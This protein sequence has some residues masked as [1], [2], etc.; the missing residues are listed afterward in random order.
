MIR[1]T[2][3]VLQARSRLTPEQTDAIVTEAQAPGGL[4]VMVEIDPREGSG[5][6]PLDWE[7]FLQPEEQPA[8]AVRGVERI[9]LVVRIHDQ[10]GRVTG[11]A[12]R[13]ASL[14]R[15]GPIQT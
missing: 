10:E 12:N 14:Q 1:A 8:D 4:V 5:V 13:N 11:D 6:I 7:A 15:R 9:E 2:A 3:R